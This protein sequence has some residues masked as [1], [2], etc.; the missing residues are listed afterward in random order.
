MLKSSK[1]FFDYITRNITVYNERE[2]QSIAFILLEDVFGLR[3]SDVLADKPLNGDTETR[4]KELVARINKYEPVQYI[5][6][7]A[8]FYGRKFKVGPSVLIPRPETEELVDLIIKENKGLKN[9]SILDVCAGSGCIGISVAKELEGSRVYALEISEEALKNCVENAALHD[10]N[11]KTQYFNLAEDTV[12]PEKA[13]VIVCNPPYV[14]EEDEDQ[15]VPNVLD[16]EPHIAIFAPQTEPLFFYK[17]ALEYG[18]L[19]LKPGGRIYFEIN[20]KFGK[21]M[22]E[23]MEKYGYKNVEVLRDINDT[24]RIAKGIL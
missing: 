3:K 23:L 10:A 1:Q 16:Y 7:L 6:G 24:D 20:E 13:D 22:K 11:V 12:A 9:L 19:N 2:R 15:M 14:T 4:V 8:A 18:K 5:T 21:E 17:K